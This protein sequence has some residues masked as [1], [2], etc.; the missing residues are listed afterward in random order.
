MGHKV[1]QKGMN[2]R[3]WL[4]GKR[5]IWKGGK[6]TEEVRDEI[7]RMYSIPMKFSNNA[8]NENYI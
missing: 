6:K 7:I 3:M 5:G 8:S 2:V 4:V 1:K